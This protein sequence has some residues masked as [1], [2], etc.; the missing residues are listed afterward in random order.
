MS[1]SPGLTD[2]VGLPWGKAT[3]NRYAEGVESEIAPQHGHNAFGVKSR[4]SVTQ[5][6]SFL[7]TL[8]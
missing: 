8:G 2:N 5:G 6:S 4:P 7:A 1:A 3:F